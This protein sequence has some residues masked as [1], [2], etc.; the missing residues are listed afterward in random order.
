VIVITIRNRELIN[1][2]L[3]N[4]LM[5]AKTIVFVASRYGLIGL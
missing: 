1:P 4:V 2:S 3:P 5:G